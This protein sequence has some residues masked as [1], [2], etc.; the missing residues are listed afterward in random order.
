MIPVKTTL[1]ET[2]REQLIRE[3]QELPLEHRLP[4]DRQLA[5]RF[6]VALLTINKV[7]QSLQ[8]DGYVER[9]RG[10]G[11]VL[12]SREKR[13]RRGGGV[14][15][16]RI[17]MATPNYF[18]YEYWSRSYIA[19]ELALKNGC[20]S[21][22]FRFGGGA[23]H[24]GLIEQARREEN[25]VGVL[26]APIADALDR[27][28]VEQLDTLGVPV[29]IF[30]RC[31]WVSFT[32]NVYCIVPDWF[33][34]GYLCAKR[35]LDAGR[36]SLAYIDNEPT[37][38]DDSL[39][40]EGIKQALYERG[41]RLKDLLRPEPRCK[42]WDDTR[43]AAY[44][45]THEALAK[46][47]DALIYVSFAGAIGGYKA[48]WEAGKR[49]PE[50]VAVVTANDFDNGQDYMCPPVTTVGASLRTEMEM[51][52]RIVNREELPVSRLILS[53]VQLHERASVTSPQE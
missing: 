9:I 28:E 24:K 35:M 5:K 16:S 52:F 20:H 3:V 21:V 37:A 41:L 17:L 15:Q 4:S 42:V 14:G 40:K 45:M 53:P 47:A 6:G 49:V 32:Q 36:R 22:D 46:G 8:A 43:A 51:A 25:L 26:L 34:S 30:F 19:E 33:Q 12:A 2:I 27:N 13:I 50:D 31:D 38:Y 18:S 23:S 1:H 44:G 29:V 39:L 7:M 11:T 10:K 48:L